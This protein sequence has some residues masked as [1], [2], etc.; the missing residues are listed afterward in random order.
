MKN[1]RWFITGVAAGGM[2]SMFL[3][4]DTPMTTTGILAT[5]EGITGIAIGLWLANCKEPAKKSLK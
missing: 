5:L 3:L 4:L 1:L 2:A